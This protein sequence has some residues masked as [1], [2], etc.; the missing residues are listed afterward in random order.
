MECRHGQEVQLFFRQNVRLGKKCDQSD[1][2]MMSV[3]SCLH[4]CLN[5][6]CLV[7]V[8]LVS[9]VYCFCIVSV[10]EFSVF[11]AI[12]LP[13]LESSQLRSHI[14]SPVAH[15][16]LFLSVTPALMSHT[17]CLPIGALRFNLPSSLGVT[18]LLCSHTPCTYSNT[19]LLI[20]TNGFDSGFLINA[21]MY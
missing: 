2:G 7:I 20:A 16:L 1:C 10:Y 14:Y 8:H 13:S 4:S 15:S 6:Y 17:L 3:L 5:T 18:S 12:G 11:I 19:Y 21:L 9:L